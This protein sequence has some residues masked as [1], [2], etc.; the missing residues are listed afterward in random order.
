[1]MGSMN[2]PTASPS[3]LFRDNVFVVLSKPPGMPTQSTRRG[4]EGSLEAWLR[5]QDGVDYTAFHHRLDA[6][7]QGLICASLDR[8]ANSRLAAAFRERTARRGYR[9]LVHGSPSPAL[10]AGTTSVER[11]SRRIAVDFELGGEER[12]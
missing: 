10:A 11:G 5:E 2:T 8:R 3:V 1:M 7:A 12:R 4:S 6:A 9:A